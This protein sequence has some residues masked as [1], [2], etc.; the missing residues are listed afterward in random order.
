MYARVTRLNG[1]PAIR[2]SEDLAREMI[3][4]AAEALGDPDPEIHVYEV[5]AQA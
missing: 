1:S 3:G 2:N 4:R 5:V